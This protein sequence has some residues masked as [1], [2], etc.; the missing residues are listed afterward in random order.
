M[1]SEENKFSCHFLSHFIFIPSSAYYS[2]SWL[3]ALIHILLCLEC[4]LPGEELLSHSVLAVMMEYHRKVV[5][6]NRNLFL[7]FTAWK[8]RLRC[9]E[10]WFP[11]RDCFLCSDNCLLA[12]SLLDKIKKKS[13][14]GSFYKGTNPILEGSTLDFITSPKASPRNTITFWISM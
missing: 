12:V 4:P 8:F 3:T 7:T 2:P 13:L 14:W 9:Q 10:M 6:N 5:Y 1:L 11:M